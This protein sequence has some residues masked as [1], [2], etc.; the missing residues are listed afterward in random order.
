MQNARQ[1]GGDESRVAIAGESPGGNLAAVTCLRARDEVGRMPV[2]QLLVYPVTNYAF[3]TPS[4]RE[5][6]ETRPLN[7]GMMKWFWGHYL[8]NESQG[9]EA[10]ASPLQAQSLQGLPP[11]IV[12]TD[13]FDPLR[14]EG[15]A[16]AKRLA[17][18][19]CRLTSNASTG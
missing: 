10:Y 11:A 12:I 17:D 2:A 3:D 4:Y 9:R 6:V 1:L 16:Y 19:E 7:A 8:E 5:S 14:D 15:E 13:E 18:G